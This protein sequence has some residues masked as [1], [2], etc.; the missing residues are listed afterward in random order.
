MAREG[1]HP[2]Y[3][4]KTSFYQQQYARPDLLLKDA[5]GQPDWLNSYFRR[6]VERENKVE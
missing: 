3:N 4:L 6:L 1:R 5:N 2:S